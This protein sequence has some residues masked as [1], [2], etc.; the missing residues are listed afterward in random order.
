MS[1]LIS[2]GLALSIIGATVLFLIVVIYGV[3]LTTLL[4]KILI[5]PK[6]PIILGSVVIFILLVMGIHRNLFGV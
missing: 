4:D 2:M 3:Y 6:Y 1:W 5:N